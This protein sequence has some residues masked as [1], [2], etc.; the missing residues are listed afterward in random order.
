MSAYSETRAIPPGLGNGRAAAIRHGWTL[1]DQVVSAFG[2]S[3]AVTHAVSR[4]QA[5]LYFHSEQELAREFEEQAAKAEEAG[6]A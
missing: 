4:A 6:V 1:L 3:H 2:A 5:A